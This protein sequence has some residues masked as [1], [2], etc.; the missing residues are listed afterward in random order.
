MSSIGH[1]VRGLRAAGPHG[2]GSSGSGDVR[3]AKHQGGAGDLELRASAGAASGR[4][5]GT[6]ERSRGRFWKSQRVATVAVIVQRGEKV[7]EPGDPA[8]TDRGRRQAEYVA[9][10]LSRSVPAAIV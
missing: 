10:A 7:R 4:S 3:S 8:L 9:A 2:A 1:V 5:C 6:S